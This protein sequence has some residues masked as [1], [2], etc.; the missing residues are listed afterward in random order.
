MQSPC[1]NIWIAKDSRAAWETTG[2]C[3]KAKK[4]EGKT[5]A[6]SLKFCLL[7]AGFLLLAL[8]EH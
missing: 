8:R 7:A 3:F 2:F 1:W 5:Q 4:P 6:F